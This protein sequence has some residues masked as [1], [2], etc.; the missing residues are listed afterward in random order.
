[1]TTDLAIAAAL[2][3]AVERVREFERENLPRQDSDVLAQWRSGRRSAAMEIATWLE[4]VAEQ[5]EG[6]HA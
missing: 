6:A 5:Y 4:Q 3:R 1:M 2:R